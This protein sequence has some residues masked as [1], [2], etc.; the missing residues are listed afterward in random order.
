M[1]LRSGSGRA[2]WEELTERPLFGLAAAFAV[3]Y[4]VPIVWPDAD[5]DVK[6]W[7][8][9]VEWG[10]WGAFALDYVVRLVLAEDRREFVRRRWLDLCAVVL[11]MLQQLR[12]L[13][14]VATLLLV[15]QRARM[16]SQIRLTT[17]VGGSVIGL[18]MFGSL[19]VLSVERDSP[20]GNIHTLGDAVWWSFTTMT[21]VGYGDHA[22]TTGLGRVL[23]V[24]LMLAGIALLGV[25]TANIAAW[26]I[27]RFEKDD[28]EERR[29][30]AA[31]AE[32]AEEVRLLRAEVAALR[33]AAG[34]V[35]KQRR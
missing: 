7:C 3:A 11:P 4:A 6:R 10:V 33:S 25:V 35:P 17:Y 24:G 29:Q 22:P 26:F 9:V 30:T 16:A 23:A 21:T 12:L 15:G 27:A 14:L 1:K 2:R 18:L 32:L 34:T 20:N 31:I 8:E 28:A 13:R 19:A 5:A